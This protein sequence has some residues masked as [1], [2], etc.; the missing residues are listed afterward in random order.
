MRIIEFFYWFKKNKVSLAII[1]LIN[2]G[3]V[4]YGYSYY[5]KQLLH[6]PL[7]L[8]PFIPDSPN[9]TLLIALALVLYAIGYSSKFLDALAFITVFKYGLWTMFVLLFHYEHYFGLEYTLRM[10]LFWLH[11]GMVLEAFILLKEMKMLSKPQWVFLTGWFFLNDVMDYMFNTHPVM[12]SEGIEI[13]R[14]VTFVMS[15]AI[16]A[17]TFLLIKYKSE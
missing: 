17:F 3:G 1:I 8:W 9:S 13:V 10:A 5:L 11:F 2:I 6:S 12:P 7:Y 16:I 14:T 15:L 4:F